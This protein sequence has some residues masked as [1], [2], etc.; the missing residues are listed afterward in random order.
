MCVRYFSPAATPIHTVPMGFS[1]V[2]PVGPAIPD[3]AMAQWL[4]R[5]FCVL[6]S[7]S[8]TVSW[9]TAPYLRRVSEDIPNRCSFISLE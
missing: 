9:L 3:T 7:I 6:C 4:R 8:I 1:G 2:P 5:R